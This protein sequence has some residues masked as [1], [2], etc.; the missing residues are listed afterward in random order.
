[1]NKKHTFLLLIFLFSCSNSNTANAKEN[2]INLS[3]APISV[4]NYWKYKCFAEGEF[5]FEKEIK[6]TQK[7]KNKQQPYYQ[8][9]L[10]TDGNTKVLK[11]FIW[12]NEEG[13]L[14]SSYQSNLKYSEIIM[15]KNPS[16]GSVI[17]ENKVIKSEWIKTPATGRIKTIR[18]KNIPKSKEKN[19]FEISSFRNYAKN[20]GL[21]SEADSLGGECELIDYKIL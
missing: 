12:L 1:M 4:G 3:Y 11:S 14:L 5:L 9:E 15:I 21:I 18:I 7:L 10:K 2:S 17:G 20:I 16:I 8:L 6:I 19:E 13:N